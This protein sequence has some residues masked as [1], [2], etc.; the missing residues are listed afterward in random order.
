MLKC[1]YKFSNIL[2][3]LIQA[4]KQVFDIGKQENQHYQFLLVEI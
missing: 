2:S 4:K 1:N 3:C